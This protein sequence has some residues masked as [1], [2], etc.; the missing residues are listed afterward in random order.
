MWNSH[1]DNK[2][3]LSGFLALSILIHFGAVV[4]FIYYKLSSPEALPETPTSLGVSALEVVQSPL[5]KPDIGTPDAAPEVNEIP[6]AEL[7]AAE[8]ELNK[9]KMQLKE[10]APS[11]P[12]IV[13]DKADVVLPTKL[14]EAKPQ[15]TKK[16]EA[17]IKQSK[18]P[19]KQPTKG[20]KKE[21]VAKPPAK[22]VAKKSKTKSNKIPTVLPGRKTVTTTKDSDVG[23]PEKTVVVAPQIKSAVNDEPSPRDSFAEDTNEPL[24]LKDISA[25][26]SA[27]ATGGF[28]ELPE[29][30]EEAV[31]PETAALAAD[32]NQTLED[33]EESSE[34]VDPNFS[35]DDA[36]AAMM[37]EAS[38]EESD[39]SPLEN[40]E[41]DSPD[42]QGN[43]SGAP[44]SVDGLR[45]ADNLKQF[46]GNRP[47]VYPQRDRL[48]RKE[49][50]VTL[51]AY[52]TNSGKPTQ[53]KVAQSSGTN[54]MNAN[55]LRAFTKYRFY[56][57]Q[58]GYVRQTYVFRLSGDTGYVPASLG[59]R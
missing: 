21:K 10:P 49:G 51:V 2:Q 27:R 7:K 57:G 30:S 11:K 19:A 47:P 44:G 5:G 23:L 3:K 37:G 1:R 45:D 36:V 35:E 34:T 13:D 56:K 29:P 39:Q 8:L 42:L 14:P 43:A 4:G 17:I 33:D 12:Q 46:P 26:N 32:L 53:I 41:A 20:L 15:N 25:V 18:L 28:D 38:D 31:D 55:S 6:E 54:R 58:A 59:S 50:V 22:K 40:E 9:A 48:S 16:P 52:V 24:N